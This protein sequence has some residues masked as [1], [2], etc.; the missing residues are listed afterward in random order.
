MEQG[1]RQSHQWRPAGRSVIH[2]ASYT[3]E[4]AVDMLVSRGVDVNLIPDGGGLSPLHWA[5]YNEH[6]ELVEYL[7]NQGA[8]SG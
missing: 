2:L 6:V 8:A 5:V 4:V 3:G 7:L 1:S